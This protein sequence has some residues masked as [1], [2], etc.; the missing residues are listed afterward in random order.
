MNLTPAEGDL[1]TKARRATLAT[2]AP[3]GR[4][5]LVPICF[6]TIDDV[7]WSPIDQKPKATGDPHGLARVRDIQ[8]RPEVTV[9]VDQWSEDWSDLAWLRLHA[10]AVLIEPSD[11]PTATVE[12]LRQRYPQYR[13]HDLEHRPMLKITLERATSWFAADR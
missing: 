3:T 7:L 1:L 11:V 12:A 4:A 9:L 13:E 8:A 5:R 2:I 10:R 6:I